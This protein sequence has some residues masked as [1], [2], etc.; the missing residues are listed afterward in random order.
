M[1]LLAIC[2]PSLE[3]CPFKSFVS[4]MSLFQPGHTSGFCWQTTDTA[5]VSVNKTG[6]TQG[7]LR[8]PR[9]RTH[10][11][12]DRL[13]N[14]VVQAVVRADQRESRLGSWG[15][16]CP[17]GRLCLLPSG[18]EGSP[19][20]P[21]RI[22]IVKGQIPISEAESARPSAVT[23]PPFV[24]QHGESAVFSLRVTTSLSQGPVWAELEPRCRVRAQTPLGPQ[25]HFPRE[26]D[27][28]IGFGS[29]CY[30]R[31]GPGSGEQGGRWGP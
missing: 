9:A 7:N 16:L 20:R 28:L 5:R 11:A 14:R 10:L 31:I 1:S 8:S 24:P 17:F 25:Q 29:C 30:S 3:N 21:G 18:E 2:V 22:G 13:G 15:F 26:Q 6:D 23:Q 19:H 27:Q 12:P 4:L